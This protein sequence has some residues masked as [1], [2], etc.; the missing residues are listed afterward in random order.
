MINYNKVIKSELCLPN[1]TKLIKHYEFKYP[2]FIYYVLKNIS[3]FL[4][5]ISSKINYWLN[6][7]CDIKTI[8]YKKWMNE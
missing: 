8:K 5:H 6:N 2:M 3:Y 4:N 1:K 7:N